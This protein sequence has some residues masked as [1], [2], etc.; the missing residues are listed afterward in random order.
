MEGCTLSLT[1]L[2][3]NVPTVLFD[4]TVADA[5][6]QACSLSNFF[7][8]EEWLKDAIEDFRRDPWPVVF[9]RYVNSVIRTHGANLD[10]PLTNRLVHRL[11]RVRQYIQEHLDHLVLVNH[12][13][14][15]PC[16]EAG[17]D[18]DVFD[19]EIVRLHLQR[20]DQ[21][22]VQVQVLLLGI[23]S[24]GEDRELETPLSRHRLLRPSSP[25][26][27]RLCHRRAYAGNKLVYA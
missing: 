8:G 19:L 14:S 5:E 4:K 16:Q 22:G 10:S 26:H 27:Q 6:S 15:I 23:S 20:A 9:N 1:A 13:F 21:N 25:L 3:P 11:L 2:Y 24:P 12:C 17:D 7:R 18:V